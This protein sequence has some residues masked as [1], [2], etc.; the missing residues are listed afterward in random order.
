MINCR[1]HANSIIRTR[2][3]YLTRQ[4]KIRLGMNEYVPSMPKALFKKI[5]SGFSAEVASAYPEINKAYKAL[6]QYLNQSRNRII[7]SNGADSAIKMVFEAFCDPG[8]TIATIAPTFAMYKVHSQLLNCKLSEIYCDNNG[9]CSDDIL[10]QLVSP[11][12]RLAI[13]ANPNGVTGYAFSVDKL[14]EFIRIAENMNVLVVIDETYADFGNIDASPLIDEFSNI[15][16]V[17]SFSKNIGMAGIRI[18]YILTTERL[19]EMIEKFKSMMEVNALAVRAVEVICSDD[20]YLKNS[21][22]K[23][24]NSRKKFANK[25]SKLGIE[26]VERSGNFVLVDFGLCKEAVI[27]KLTDSNIEFKILPPPLSRYIRLTVGLSNIMDQVVSVIKTGIDN[28]NMSNKTK[29]GS[30]KNEKGGCNLKC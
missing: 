1:K 23:I 22:E 4:D 14:R 24:I 18:G 2:Q 19:A 25:L 13:I 3:E 30:M 7:L 17:R 10:L 28:G 21:V 9:K 5:I 8:D 6:S 29:S 15:V 11:A 27:K 26:V 20:K 16:I 12:I